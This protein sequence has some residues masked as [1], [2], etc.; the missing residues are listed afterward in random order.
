MKD[1][2]AIS[3]LKQGDLD[4]LESLVSRYQAE[5]VHAAFIILHDRSSAQEVVQSAFVKVAERIHQFED[6]RR[7]APWFF[8]IVVN[9]ALKLARS[10]KRY[11]S[12]E[13][14]LDAP[15]ANL[16]AWLI[17][18]DPRPE[19]LVEQKESRQLILRAIQ[20]LPPGQRAV[21][22]MRYFLDMSMLDMAADMDRPLSTIKWW[23]RDA[24]K[25]LRRRVES[26]QVVKE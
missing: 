11:V 2:K 23:L 15:A 3:R 16:A 5:A 8:R 9:D 17:H 12:L 22:V 10:N 24:R 13:Q 1:R 4:G 20:S 18:P 26:P 6:H 25:R 19:Y 21:I 14:Q 7:F